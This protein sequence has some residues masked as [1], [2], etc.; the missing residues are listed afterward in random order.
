MEGG[1]SVSRWQVVI[2]HCYKRIIDGFIHYWRQS[3]PYQN[4][5]YLHGFTK[6]ETLKHYLHRD[7][8]NIHLL[9]ADFALLQTLSADEVKGISVIALASDKN[10]ATIPFPC[11]I[12]HP[13]Q[14]LSKLF[15]TMNEVCNQHN[16]VNE[17]K[18]I[19]KNCRI[20]AVTSAVGGTGKSTVA[21]H[22]AKVIAQ[23]GLRP[24]LLNVDRIQ[25]YGLLW[26]D[27]GMTSSNN[28]ENS[29][30]VLFYHF[31]KMGEH[32]LHQLPTLTP[33]IA[34]VPAIGAYMFNPKQLME[35]WKWIDGNLGKKLLRAIQESGQFDFIIV[36]GSWHQKSFAVS[37]QM[38]DCVMWLLLDD[39]IHIQKT[40]LLLTQ[41]ARSDDENMQRRSKR[42]QVVVNRYMGSMLNSWTNS[43]AT[44]TGY[45]PYIST[46]KQIY[47]V[48]QWLQSTVFQT[49]LRQWVDKEL[50]SSNGK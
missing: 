11:K 29:L 44:I 30:S 46:W 35:E 6:A 47:C 23:A 41:W 12:E 13:Y 1:T 17:N 3:S 19:Q 34:F 4:D 2:A 18:D 40:K 27:L 21:L 9:V 20:I 32:Q 48:E 28:P 10:I 39:M 8:G 22:L 37:W 36:E 49:I 45:L 16:L 31:R 50:L 38:S 14:P 43:D 42:L 7:R 5:F 33:Y 24:F 26:T 15:Q 25:E